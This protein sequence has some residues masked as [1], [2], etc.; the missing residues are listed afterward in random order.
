MKR[1]KE[2]LPVSELDR[3]VSGMVP[4]AGRGFVLLYTVVSLLCLL[5][6]VFAATAFI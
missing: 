2:I 4:A 3:T 6:S 1:E 5:L